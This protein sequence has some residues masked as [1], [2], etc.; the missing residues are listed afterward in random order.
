MLTLPTV[1]LNGTSRTDLFNAISVALDALAEARVALQATAPNGRDY[2]PQGEM[3]I[4]QA[5]AEHVARLRMLETVY[6]ELYAVA[7]H[8][9]P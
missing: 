9:Q 1:H 7:E 5:T 2:Y 8:V 3:A 6:A 4:R